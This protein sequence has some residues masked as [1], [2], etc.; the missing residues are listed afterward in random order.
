[1]HRRATHWIIDIRPRLATPA[2]F[3]FGAGIAVNSQPPEAAA[4][5]LRAALAP[6]QP[7]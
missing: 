2:G 3:E 4:A 6:G 5:L 1:V 7:H